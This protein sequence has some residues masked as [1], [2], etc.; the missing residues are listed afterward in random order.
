LP[1]ALSESFPDAAEAATQGAAGQ[2]GLL[3]VLLG[4]VVGVD[5]GD[6][7]EARRRVWRWLEGQDLP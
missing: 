4:E 2:D 5:P 1:V 3:A 7:R 6:V